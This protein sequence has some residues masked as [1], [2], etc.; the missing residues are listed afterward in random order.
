LGFQA[1]A[2]VRRVTYYEE[3]GLKPGANSDN[4]R[5][6]YKNLAR[7]LHPD[8]QQDSELRRLAEVQMKRLNFI[9]EV[10]TDP[11][12]RHQYDAGLLGAA[13]VTDIAP[14]RRPARAWAFPTRDFG[15]LAAGA[16]AGFVVCLLIP[17]PVVNNLSRPDNR[18]AA[19]ESVARLP[20]K[21]SARDLASS[22][23]LAPAR[24]LPTI[25]PNRNPEDKGPVLPEAA[26]SENSIP[27]P[28]PVLPVSIP[29]LGPRLASQHPLST[30]HGDPRKVATLSGTW[31]YVRPRVTTTQGAMYTAE[32][33]EAV[34]VER[35][36]QLRGRYRARYNV[37]DRP[38]SSEV[39]FT[40]EGF[41]SANAADLTWTGAGGARGDLKMKLVSS[42][43]LEITW[44]ASDLGSQMGLASGTAILTRR[45]E[46]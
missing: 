4:I 28:E 22:P 24:P 31:V 32:Y 21:S 41:H 40:F 1:H 30:A 10:L 17:G 20:D 6:A 33:V 19:D 46:P 34:I 36:G 37:P 14:V 7:L 18:R 45:Q 9:E 13:K 26:P 43:R 8:Q 29:V 38:I 16:T 42:N 3:L 2:F 23:H 12:R 5:L 25:L 39:A 35:E 15:L 11:V 44:T 27:D